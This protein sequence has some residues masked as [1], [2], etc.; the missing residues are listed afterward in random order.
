MTQS[1]PI[2]EPSNIGV[3]LIDAQPAFWQSAH[4]EN[5]GARE[6]VMARLEH[7]L[8]LADWLELPV[9]ATFEH[10]V[11]RNGELPDRL[12]RVFPAHG[13]R[14]TKCTY[15]CCLEPP[16]WEAIQ[17]LT[18][19]QLAL[20]GAE[21]DVCVLQSALALL[22]AGYQVFLLEDCLFTSE[23]QPGPALR[24]LV[25]A[26][27]VPTTFKS[28]A[29]ELTRSVEHT[30]WLDTW[31]GR[32]PEGDRPFPAGFREPESLPEWQPKW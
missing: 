23:P 3:L 18:V 4:W 25:A 26:G 12:E 22:R 9:I 27:A 17:A 20:A 15:N 7:L 13:G 30:P 28:F 10:P 24:R 14:F 29:Y 19:R 1:I 11:A 31:I 5:E 8:M 6:A 2:L 32:G 16:I 21:T